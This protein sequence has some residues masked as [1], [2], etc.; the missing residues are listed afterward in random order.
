MKQF[1]TSLIVA[2]A[3]T[4]ARGSSPQLPRSFEQVT[5]DVRSHTLGTSACYREPRDQTSC[6]CSAVNDLEIGIGLV[7]ML[8]LLGCQ[9]RSRILKA[10]YIIVV[11]R[12]P[13]SSLDKLHSPFWNSSRVA[14][15]V[16]PRWLRRRR[17]VRRSVALHVDVTERCSQESGRLLV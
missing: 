4:V 7:A 15:L 17:Y 9:S 5:K 10:L 6:S 11:A 14:H 13:S 12:T 16:V 8:V 1:G 3:L 2:N